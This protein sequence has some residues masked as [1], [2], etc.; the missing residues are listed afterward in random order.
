MNQK[1]LSQ[2]ISMFR[3][4]YS[5]TSHNSQNRNKST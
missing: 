4:R 5:A 2:T 1:M 3:T